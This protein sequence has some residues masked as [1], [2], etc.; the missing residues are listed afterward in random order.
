MG[1]R[2]R[3]HLSYAN[4]MATVAVFMV[5]GGTALGASY[6][7][8]S[9][10]QVAPNTI[11]GHKPPVGKHAN[12]IG[13]SLNATDLAPGAVTLSKLGS[14]SVN[15]TRV[16]NGSLTAAD[17]NTTSLQRRITG[18]CPSGQAATSVT[19]AGALTCDTPNALG[20]DALFGDGSDGDQTISS[21]TALNR[22]TYYHDLT[23]DPGMTLNPGGFRI[24]VSGTLTM[25][26]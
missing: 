16:V 23:I 14:N 11:S 7:V 12:V 21:N 24:F 26:D 15:G 19:Q 17:A 9:N 4:V 2:L 13:G 8:S 25:G 22:D 5:L 6:V 10:S 20:F 18:V 3:S 1:P